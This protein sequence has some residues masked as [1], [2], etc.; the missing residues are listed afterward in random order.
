MN[1]N[2]TNKHPNPSLRKNNFDLIRLVCALFVV[3]CHSYRIGFDEDDPLQYISNDSLSFSYLGVSSFFVISGYLITQSFVS[4]KK[5]MHFFVKRCLRIFPGLAVCLVFSVFLAGPVV[6][7]LPI[8][9]YFGQPD[10]YTYFLNI[11][12]FKQ[13]AYL[14]GVFGGNVVNGSL[15]TLPYE[16]YFYFIILILGVLGMLHR[17][18]LASVF[19]LMMGILIKLGP[20]IEWYEYSHWIVGFQIISTFF[21]FL[22]YFL[23]GSLYYL[24]FQGKSIPWWISL[25][26]V[27]FFYVTRDTHLSNAGSVLLIP[28][29]VFAIAFIPGKLNSFGKRGDFSYGVYIYGWP[30]Q[31]TLAA[32]IGSFGHPLLFFAISATAV[33]IPAYLSWTYIEK[34]AL[35]LKKYLN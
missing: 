31:A 14:P 4:D 3:F 22:M 20:N 1:G 26:C 9:E 34:P 6:T 11:T 32:L 7:D 10:T 19:I 17:Y 29:L 13:Q 35:S 15:W 25:L 18:I 16:F 28:S 33:L 30:V 2:F 24:F 12:L 8:G 21:V 5:P 27:L 23:S